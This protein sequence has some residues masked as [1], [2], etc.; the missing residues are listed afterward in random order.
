MASGPITS[1]QM[2]REKVEAVTNFL[3][4]GLK[5]TVDGD[6]SHEIKRHLLLGSKAMTDLGSIFKSKV[7][8]FQTKDKSH[9]SFLRSVS[10]DNRNKNNNKKMEPKKTHK[11]LY[12]KGNH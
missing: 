11:L 2:E 1:R 5:I 7:I 8:T 4:L 6:C 10:Q 12:S 3:F 9:Q